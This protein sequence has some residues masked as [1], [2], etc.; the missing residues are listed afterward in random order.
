MEYRLQAVKLDSVSDRLKAV[1]HA[2]LYAVLHAMMRPY[3]MD[4]TLNHT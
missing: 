2:V 1:L 4:S 3:E